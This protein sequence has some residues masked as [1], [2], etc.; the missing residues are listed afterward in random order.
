MRKLPV[1]FIRLI[2]YFTITKASDRNRVTFQVLWDITPYR[3]V[4]VSRIFEGKHYVHCYGRQSCWITLFLDCLNQ[5]MK[6]LRSFGTLELP[7]QRLS[8]ISMKTEI[9]R[10]SA[11]ITTNL[12]RRFLYLMYVLESCD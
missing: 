12:E 9:F 4:R 2:Y 6:A 8:F 11:M 10:N 1:L 5:A 7:P 3:W